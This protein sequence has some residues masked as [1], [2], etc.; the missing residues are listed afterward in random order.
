[1]MNNKRDCCLYV[2]LLITM[3]SFK[4]IIIN[5]IIYFIFLNKLFFFFE[6]PYKEL[7]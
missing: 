6:I 3:N 4:I 7:K 5:M 1:M 2:H